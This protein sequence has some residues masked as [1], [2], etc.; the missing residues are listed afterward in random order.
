MENG[1]NNCSAQEK[2]DLPC[3]ICSEAHLAEKI[4][5]C[6][7]EE[8]RPL[9]KPSVKKSIFVGVLILSVVLAS[10][11]LW[12]GSKSKEKYSVSFE[13][14]SPSTEAWRGAFESR[15]INEACYDFAVSIRIGGKGEYAAPAASGV[16]ISEDGW[17]ATSADILKDNRRGRIYVRIGTDSEYAVES[18]RY[19]S[20]YGVSLLKIEIDGLRVPQFREKELLCVGEKIVAISSSGAPDHAQTLAA[21]ILTGFDRSASQGGTTPRAYGLI[22]TD[23][24]F[25]G[26]SL[27]SPVFD[28][29]GRLIGISL[30][31]GTGFLLPAKDLLE[32]YK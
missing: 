29:S 23:L 1:K 2:T 20:E 3:E 5:F 8:D 17:I 18:V 15:E 13:A 31:E 28:I 9:Q 27:G 12:I 16:V 26:A 22:A 4:H 24:V 30:Y 10:L 14:D 6:Q 32:L 19:D 11:W 25:D 21:G 7:H